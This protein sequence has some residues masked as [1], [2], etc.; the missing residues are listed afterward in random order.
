M[1]TAMANGADDISVADVAGQAGVSLRTVYQH[2]PDKVARVEAINDWIDKQVDM[3]EVQS[4][5][6]EG[7]F[8]YMAAAS[9]VSSPEY[10]L[11]S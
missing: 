11:Q 4:G 5:A 10:R 9:A 2:F 7:V 8:N 1:V 3:S 6:C